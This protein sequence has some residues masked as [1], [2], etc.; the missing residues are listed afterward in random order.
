MQII[1]CGYGQSVFEGA[2][3]AGFKPPNFRVGVVPN[4]QSL[5]WEKPEPVARVRADRY[6][7]GYPIF[8][9]IEKI[10]EDQNGRM[11]E[12]VGE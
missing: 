8:E 12:R 6:S 1:Q 3:T 10:K 11:A 2:I 4:A 9:R 5:P 7:R